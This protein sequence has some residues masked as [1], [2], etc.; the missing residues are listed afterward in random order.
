M[1]YEVFL[2][3]RRNLFLIIRTLL[4]GGKAAALLWFHR[5]SLQ[6]T[7]LEGLLS[8]MDLI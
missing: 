4:G 8:N 3:N 1:E 7:K 6:Q 5:G 2:N